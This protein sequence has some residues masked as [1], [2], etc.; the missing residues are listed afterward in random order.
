MLC[1]QPRRKIRITNIDMW[2]QAFNIYCYILLK[3]YQSIATSLIKYGS[4]VRSIAMLGG[5]FVGFDERFRRIRQETLCAWDSFNAENFVLAMCAANA[6]IATS[7][8]NSRGSNVLPTADHAWIQQG[9]C[10]IYH[11]G[12]SCSGC[13]LSHACQWCGGAH[14][15]MTCS[16]HRSHDMPLAR[17]FLG[18]SHPFNRYRADFR[19]RFVSMSANSTRGRGRGYPSAP[20]Q[21]RR[22]P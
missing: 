10:F 7:Y 18:N 16:Q 11:G 2:L 4:N 22:R 20:G 17:P 12:R 13:N 15:A 21:A 3:K 9:Y 5:D 6:N 19:P 1:L 14:P 8:P